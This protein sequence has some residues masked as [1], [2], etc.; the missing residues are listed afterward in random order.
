MTLEQ[1]RENLIQQMTLMNMDPENV[2]DKVEILY[3]GLI[4]KNLKDLNEKG[5]WIQLFKM[6]AENLKRSLDYEILVVD[7]L[8]VL[9]MAAKMDDHRSEM[10]YL[11]SML[12][13][14]RGDRERETRLLK[15]SVKED[16]MRAWPAALA[17]RRLSGEGSGAL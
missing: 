8:N 17:Q 1:S 3:L 5:T 11:A 2:K 10:F 15:L 9:Y 7:S 12:Y 16:P 6:Y 13:G 14:K 4:R